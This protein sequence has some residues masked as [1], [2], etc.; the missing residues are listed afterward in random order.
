[1]P[2][3]LKKKGKD[4]YN[5]CAELHDKDT[6]LCNC[7]NKVINENKEIV[8]ELERVKKNEENRR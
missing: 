2:L 3:F 1:M 6:E 4:N 5:K 7:Y 8:L